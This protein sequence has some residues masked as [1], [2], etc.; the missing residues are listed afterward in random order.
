SDGTEAGTRRILQNPGAHIELLGTTQAGQAYFNGGFASA[1][2]VTAGTVN[3]THSLGTLFG[4]FVGSAGNAAVL[5]TGARPMLSLWRS[6]G[7]SSG[8]IKIHDVPAKFITGIGGDGSSVFFRAVATNGEQLWQTDGTA[9]GT[10]EVPDFPVT[11]DYYYLD[12]I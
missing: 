10:F 1:T 2:G 6:N 9:D 8:T 5:T 4:G 11:T 7:T 3:S 12:T